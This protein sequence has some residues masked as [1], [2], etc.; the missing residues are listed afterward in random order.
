M[1]TLAA[2]RAVTVS[3]RFLATA[4][5]MYN[6]TLVIKTSDPDSPTINV[7]LRGLGTS[8]TGGANEPSLQRVLD[9]HQI[10]I[11]TGDRDALTTVL[12]DGS[13]PLNTPNDEISIPR[14][15]KSGMRAGH[16]GDSRWCSAQPRTH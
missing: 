2:W 6:A 16:D 8:G 9:L 3:V 7:P 4:V 11:V 14:F 10:P 13:N 5:R 12:Y 1:S 15:V